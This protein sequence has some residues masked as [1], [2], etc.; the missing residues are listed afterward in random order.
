MD[1][2]AKAGIHVPETA[3]LNLYGTGELKAIGGDAGS[4][5]NT[6]NGNRGGARW[7]DGA[8]AGIGGNGRSWRKWK[9]IY[10]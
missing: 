4:G 5:G 3:T 9:S 8:G 10:M 6:Q 1:H 7:S 2:G